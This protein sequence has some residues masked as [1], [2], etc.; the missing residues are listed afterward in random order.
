MSIITKD[1]E[2]KLGTEKVE[3]LVEKDWKVAEP[4]T[5]EELAA[6]EIK[7][8]KARN[9]PN[10]RKNLAQYNQRSKE[11]KKKALENL[12]V[13]EVEED[14]DPKVIFGDMDLTTIEKI[15]PARNVLVNREEQEIYYNVIKLFLQDFDIKE[16]SFGDIDD[17]VTLAV[18]RVLEYRLLKV[19]AQSP[20]LVLEAA[21]TLEKLRKH[22]DNIKKNLASRRVDRIDLKTKPAMSIVDL[23][24]HL[25]EQDRLDFNQ[26]VEDLKK[27]RQEYR[28]P[29]RDERGRL[30]DED[31]KLIEES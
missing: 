2:E 23:A 27:G 28:P 19:S 31:G 6:E 29:L 13:T 5:E 7:H 14:I 8:P 26:R 22:S 21:P 12:T 20:K 16:L 11:A 18:N 17:I 24:A 30:I 1:L 4:P 9:N 3:E 15:M 10:S 25:D